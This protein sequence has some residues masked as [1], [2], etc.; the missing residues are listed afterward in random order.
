MQILVSRDFYL[1]LLSSSVEAC[2]RPYPLVKGLVIKCTPRNCNGVCKSE[3]SRMVVSCMC[4]TK[5]KN[6]RALVLCPVVSHAVVSCRVAY[7]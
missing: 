3:S 1:F 5:L 6:R 7:V 4:G 2:I